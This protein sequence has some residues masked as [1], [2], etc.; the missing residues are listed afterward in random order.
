[1]D[2]QQGANDFSSNRMADNFHSKGLTPAQAKVR[3]ML[4]ELGDLD[5]EKA[6]SMPRLIQLDADIN[7][8]FQP[9]EVPTLK[10]V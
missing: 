3:D 5:P 7:D 10:Y 4:G 9:I 1:M 8:V 2:V 6:P